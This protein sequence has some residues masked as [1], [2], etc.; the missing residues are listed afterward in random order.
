M[1]TRIRIK[2]NGISLEGQL[3]DSPP[4]RA[5][6]ERLP[7]ELIMSRWGDEYYGDLGEAL[8][9]FP[10]EQKELMEVGELAYWEPGN[11]LCLFF[12]PTP[13][14]EGDEPRAASPVH[15]VGKV[16][17]DWESLKALGAQVQARVER[18]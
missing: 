11:A 7:V 3:N 2:I 16:E 14:S 5:I 18:A 6:A 17:G 9:E 1:A 15:P 10:G 8:G 13:A 12:G 4:A